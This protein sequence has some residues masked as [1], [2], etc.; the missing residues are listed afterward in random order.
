[1]YIVTENSLPTAFDV[2]LTFD[3]DG[4]PKGGLAVPNE[5]ILSTRSN[6]TDWTNIK[7][8]PEGTWQLEL[9]NTSVIKQL[10]DNEKITDILLVLTCDGELPEY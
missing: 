6:A 1:M 9:P 8:R 5:N 7:G 10:F 3:N 4:N 2:T